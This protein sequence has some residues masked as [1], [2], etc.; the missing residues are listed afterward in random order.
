MRARQPRRRRHSRADRAGVARLDGAAAP[1]LVARRLRHLRRRDVLR[2]RH[3]H[4]GDLGAGR[5]RGL[6]DHRAG[7]ASVHRAG[8]DRHHR[9]RCSRSRSAAPRASARCSARS[10]ACG[11]STLAVLGAMRDRCAAR[12]C[13][14]RRQSAV[15]GSRSS[16]RNPS[17]AFLALG[18][19][20]LAVTGTEALYADMGH[21]GTTPIRRAWLLF[22]MPAL[23][24]NYFGQGALILDRPGGDQEPVLPARAGVGADPARDPRDRRGGDRVA[25]GDLGRVLADPR[26]DPDGLLPAAHDRAHVRARDRRRSTC[27]SST[28]RCSRRDRCSSSVSATPT[29]SAARTASR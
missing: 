12:R 13:S 27:R 20:V 7:A 10:C 2:R 25:G 19:V 11:S 1:A 14:R 17:L 3:D 23:V 16:S 21:F 26:G 24:L 4:A 8:R 15:R 29:T 5:G 22:V 28:G 6:G 9:S 18:A